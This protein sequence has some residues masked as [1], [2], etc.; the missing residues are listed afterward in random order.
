MST[1]VAAHLNAA[2]VAMFARPGIPT[3]PLAEAEE[4]RSPLWRSTTPLL[5]ARS[6]WGIR[7]QAA[8]KREHFLN[9]RKEESTVLPDLKV[10]LA[11]RKIRQADLA[12]SLG[13]SPSVVS[14]VVNGHHSAD[15][16]RRWPGY[17]K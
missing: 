3:E 8:A 1:T 15:S 7:G 16:A 17:A 5:F 10:A 14:E 2:D 4:I 12:I 11:A 6:S 13:I 9:F